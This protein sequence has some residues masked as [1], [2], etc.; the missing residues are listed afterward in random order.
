MYSPLPSPSYL[1]SL[2]DFEKKNLSISFW[3]SELLGPNY[4]LPTL[5]W[6]N[7]F[8]QDF[9]SKY[10]C[11][12]VWDQFFFSPNLF[13]PHITKPK[14]LPD[15]IHVTNIFLLFWTKILVGKIFFT[16]IFYGPNLLWIHIFWTNIF[17]TEIF[18]C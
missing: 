18:L 8:N 11:I 3:T 2:P 6:I 16:D 4:F 5:F 10:L 1:A 14:S 17:C 13:E 15:Q 9:W 12:L 7:F